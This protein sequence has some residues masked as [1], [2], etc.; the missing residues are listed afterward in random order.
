MASHQNTPQTVAPVRRLSHRGGMIQ[1][2]EVVVVPEGT[3]RWKFGR[4]TGDERFAPAGEVRAIGDGLD[5][6]RDRDGLWVTAL[7]LVRRHRPAEPVL[8]DQHAVAWAAEDPAGGATADP[9]A[10]A[11]STSGKAKA[12]GTTLAERAA[13]ASR[14]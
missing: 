1:R 11:R 5:A 13:R 8:Y 4:R 6:D 3:G 9:T 14:R 7:C 2:M 12:A 10:W